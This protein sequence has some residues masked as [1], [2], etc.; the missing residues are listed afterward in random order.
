[1]ESS[2]IQFGVNSLNFLGHHVT[3]QGIQSLPEKV[4]AI[5]QFPQPTT[6]CKRGYRV[7]GPDQGS[8]STN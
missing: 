2:S 7:P 4:E 1:M 3:A 5:Q 6:Q 8:N